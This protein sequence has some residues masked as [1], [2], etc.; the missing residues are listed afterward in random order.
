MR[1]AWLAG[2]LAVAACGGG[3]QYR[4][5]DIEIRGLSARAESLVIKLFPEQARGGCA[6]VEL[7]NVS[8]LEAPIEERW[9]RSSGAPRTFELPSIDDA[10]LT[11][12]AY[13]LDAG[14]VPMQY[15]CLF[16]SYAQAGSLQDHRLVLTLSRRL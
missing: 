8:G 6:Q 9:E 3:T 15:S 13:S 4:P 16:V 7:S 12:I 5:L 14:G 2:A 10:G 11:I 1:W